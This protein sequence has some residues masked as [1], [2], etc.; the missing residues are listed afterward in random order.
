MG[1]NSFKLSEPVK[2]LVEASPIFPS[3][4]ALSDQRGVGGEDYPLSNTTVTLATDFTIVKLQKGI[5]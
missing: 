2:Q 1:Y 5:M 3:T 4:G